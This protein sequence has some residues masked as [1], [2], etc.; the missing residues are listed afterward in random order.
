MPMK[1]LVAGLQ[2]PRFLLLSPSRALLLARLFA[3]SL[4]H[5]FLLLLLIL[6]RTVSS[7][8]RHSF[9]FLQLS[10]VGGNAPSILGLIWDF[11]QLSHGTQ[12]KSVSRHFDWFSSL[13]S[14]APGVIRPFL[15]TLS[16][17]SS[18]PAVLG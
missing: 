2:T 4:C 18:F 8:S 15:L 9:I 16:L 5:S 14:V 11:S 12:F 13:L 7:F 10:Q 17:L 6:P 1:L 3:C